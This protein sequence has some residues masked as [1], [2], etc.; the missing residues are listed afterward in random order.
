[1]EGR[2]SFQP[3]FTCFLLAHRCQSV[4]G[5][6]SPAPLEVAALSVQCVGLGFLLTLARGVE[7]GFP[8][9]EDTVC[10]QCQPDPVGSNGRQCGKAA[11]ALAQVPAG[12]PGGGSSAEG[13]PASFPE[14][15]V[16]R[17]SLEAWAVPACLLRTWLAA[18]SLQAPCLGPFLMKTNTALL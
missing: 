9:S 8:L 18:R 5:N 16:P 1:M 3:G 7:T 14:V 15:A 12:A 2:V 11:P 10:E 4:W 6:L 17:S 13:K